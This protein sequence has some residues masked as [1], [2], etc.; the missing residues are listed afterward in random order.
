MRRTPCGRWLFPLAV[1]LTVLSFGLSPVLAG[2]TREVGAGK[3]YDDIQDAI[4]ASVNGDRVLVYPGVYVLYPGSADTVLTYGG[5]NIVVESTNPHNANAVAN[6]IIELAPITTYQT[7]YSLVAMINGESRS[8]V[9][10]GFTVRKGRC[11]YYGAGIR[12]TAG[13]RP[14]IEH[15]VF[16]DN[17]CTGGPGG[18]IFLGG[19]GL[20]QNCRFEDN[21][22]QEILDFASGGGAICL[23]DA[24][25]AVIRNN[26]FIGNHAETGEVIDTGNGGAIKVGSSSPRIYGNTFNGNSAPTGSAI[27]VAGEGTQIYENRFVNNVAGEGNGGTIHV[28]TACEIFD[29]VLLRNEA[30]RGAGIVIDQGAPNVHHNLICENVADYYAGNNGGG[31]YVDFWAG[32]SLIENNTIAYNRAVASPGWAKG[33]NVFVRGAAITLKNNIIAFGNDG[34]GV[35]INSGTPLP[36]L[37]RNDVF[38][39][40]GGNYV[41][42]A[43][44]TGKNGN[45]S[46][47]PLF[48]DP[49][50][51]DYHLSSRRGHWTKG[52][53]MADPIH[54]PCI[55]AGPT[56]GA[57]TLEPTPNGG[58]RNLGAYGGTAQASKSFPVPAPKPDMRIRGPQEGT[59]WIGNNIYSPTGKNQRVVANLKPGQTAVFDLLIQNDE[60]DDDMFILFGIPS[61]R[62]EVEVKYF[63]A[64]SGGRDI[65]DAICGSGWKTAVLSVGQSKTLR[66]QAK[67]LAGAPAG[68]A[69]DLSVWAA[70]V[71]D[72]Y[73]RKDLVKA[74]VKTVAAT[75]AAQVTAL[76]VLPTAA[77]AEVRFV[78]SAAAPV[79]ATIRNLAGRPVRALCRDRECPAGGSTLLWDGRSDGGLS[80]PSGAYLVELTTTSPDGARSRVLAPLQFAR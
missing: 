37:S 28:S 64:P 27:E 59:A 17:D 18:A 33:A 24:G 76:T 1:S 57:G 63:N 22:A 39:N 16:I 49:G 53:W 23:K 21:H 10:R 31:I 19:P 34:G 14:T 35:Y 9:F 74:G 79:T 52:G 47:D 32:G 54:S 30:R 44:Q 38:G 36:V 61:P 78:L 15:C 51:D 48:V 5:R 13:A 71:S 69:F 50:G 56:L 55:D 62:S 26:V 7:R 65:T 67:A 12:V 8:A 77:G 11:P 70:S 29:N 72:P 60:T 42:M 73:Y 6:T 25:E 4:S 75:A 66:V 45:L 43:D 68:L 58:K 41:G 20:V 80:V 40:G 46:V 3:T 2:V